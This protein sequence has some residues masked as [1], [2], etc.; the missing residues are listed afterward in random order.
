[1]REQETHADRWEN[2]VRWA[3]RVNRA[4]ELG[5]LV[6]DADGDP[7]RAPIE[8]RGDCLF[9]PCRPGDESG[10]TYFRNDPEYDEGLYTPIAEWN[11]AHEITCFGRV[12]LPEIEL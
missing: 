2:A 5:H 4:L 8:V 7:I 12:P 1:M 9:G 6:F 10:W 11:A 3:R